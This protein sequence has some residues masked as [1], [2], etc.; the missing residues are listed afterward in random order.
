MK[1]YG[2]DEDAFTSQGD[3]QMFKDGDFVYSFGANAAYKLG[4]YTSN[5]GPAWRLSRPLIAGRKAT[6][7]FY[8]DDDMLRKDVACQRMIR[9]PRVGEKVA[10]ANQEIWKCN[11][12]A[13][14]SFS[15][16]RGNVQDFYRSVVLAEKLKTG[17]IS[18]VS[19]QEVVAPFVLLDGVEV[20]VGDIWKKFNY[21][22]MVWLHYSVMEVRPNS[23]LL[24]RVNEEGWKIEYTIARSSF[25]ASYAEKRLR[26]ISRTLLAPSTITGK[27][28]PTQ[29]ASTGKGKLQLLGENAPV[30]EV[31]QEWQWDNSRMRVDFID[32]PYVYL[33]SS[34]TPTP[35]VKS[36]SS[37]LFQY[38][39]FQRAYN[40]GQM[41]LMSAPVSRDNTTIL[42]TDLEKI[43]EYC[44][45][46]VKASMAE[47][48]PKESKG[49]VRADW[50]I[51][52][53]F[54]SETIGD[55]L[56][57][58]GSKWRHYTGFINTVISI[59]NVSTASK[60]HPAMVASQD[61]KGR[62]HVRSVNSW[63]R[64]FKPV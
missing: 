20:K 34:V 6:T 42:K 9:L 49:S 1:N 37:I 46:D 32:S 44:K 47:P 10:H 64:S 4:G 15:F 36:N 41:V 61:E 29:V 23:V 59:P 11:M 58:R 62:V 38:G 35:L 17:K 57:A 60:K 63:A 26:L 3:T 2:N 7:V 19:P 40:K 55:L 39:D 14:D 43:K 13:F 27:A 12:A 5:I 33:S 31:G 25:A 22:G 45:R 8:L 56:P 54:H 52:H 30:V 48:T 18:I 24:M 28:R 51:S 16:L 21:E 53:A 50:P